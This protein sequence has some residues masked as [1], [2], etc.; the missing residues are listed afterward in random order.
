[1]FYRLIARLSI[2]PVPADTGDFRL[3]SSRAVCALQQFP[4][5]HRF[6]KGLFGWIGFRHVAVP[7]QRQPRMS[8]FSKFSVWR[9]WNFALEGITSFSTI[10]LRVTTYLGLA[11]PCFAFLFGG[12]VIVRAVIH[13]DRVPGWPSL[14]AVIVL[15]G[16][17]QLIALGFIGEY[18]GRL[19]DEVK[20]RPLY[21]IQ[22]RAG[23][24]ERAPSSMPLPV[25]SQEKIL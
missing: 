11:T 1:M 14:M 5:R 6:M 12:W 18:L 10:P 2:T 8:G 19:Y 7:Y 15:L 16:G 20:Q 21:L 22:E 25:A 24:K 23:G 4:K 17:V 13:G 9:L 3:L